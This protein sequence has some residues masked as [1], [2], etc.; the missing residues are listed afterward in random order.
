MKAVFATSQ[1]NKTDHWP[2]LLHVLSAT[3]STPPYRKHRDDGR[4]GKV[5]MF[6]NPLSGC[7]RHYFAHLHEIHISRKY[8]PEIGIHFLVTAMD[9]T[10]TLQAKFVLAC[11]LIPL[12]LFLANVRSKGA[13][14]EKIPW[15]GRKSKAFSRVRASFLSISQARELVEEGYYKVYDLPSRGTS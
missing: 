13:V 5:C 11:C 15:V 10:S 3:Q 6:P 7:P 1:C 2:V 4:N 12:L 14:L 9:W 8:L